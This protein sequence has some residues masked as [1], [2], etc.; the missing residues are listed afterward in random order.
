MGGLMSLYIGGQCKNL[1]SSVSAF[2]PADN[3]PLFGVKG[4]QAV[5]PILEMWRSLKGTPTRLTYT[6]GDWLIY[7]DLEIKRLWGNSDLTKFS[8]HEAHFPNHWAGD[9]DKQL[10]Y[11]ME[12]FSKNSTI[13]ESWNYTA[14]GFLSFDLLGYKVD[15]TRSEVGL[16]LFDHINAGLLSIESRKFLPDGEL[17]KDEKIRVVSD[18]IFTPNSKVIAYNLSDK[19]FYYPP[20]SKSDEGKLSF[21]LR[22]GGNVVGL[23]GSNTDDAAKIRLTNDKNRQYYYF[24]EGQNYNLDFKVVNVGVNDA[25]NVEIKAISDHPYISILDNKVKVKKIESAKAFEIEDKFNL[26]IHKYDIESSVGRISFEIKI[27]GAV[28]DTQKI[29]F[30]TTAKA[31]YADDDDVIILDGRSVDR[32]PVFIQGSDKVEKVTL[33]GGKGNGD[34]I[35]DRGEE[36]LI[37]IRLAQGGSAADTNTF[38]KT[39][40]LN[41]GD[42]NDLSIDLRYSEKIRQAGATS[43][44]TL[45]KLSGEAPPSSKF[46]LWFKVENLFNEHTNVSDQVVYAHKYDYR[47]VKMGIDQ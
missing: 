12:Q 7:N 23:N 38:H 36:A 41:D 17:I 27:D 1:V 19:D 4:K 43:I 22:G 15:V 9:S 33:S 40:L 3:I 5:F 37:Y 16:T 14:A 44:F 42:Y 30:F 11:H 10:D 20:T 24:E 25:D 31:P 34:G 21:E 45:L 8:F 46:D 29:I 2:C 13:P 47:R 35:L 6:D 28:V 32:V 18:R 39:Y 26:I